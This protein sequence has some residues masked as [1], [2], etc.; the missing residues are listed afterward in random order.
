MDPIIVQYG[1]CSGSIIDD[2]VNDLELPSFHRLS[3]VSFDSQSEWLMGMGHERK[4]S[5][6]IC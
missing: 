4:M 2:L 1:L 6:S 5:Q 3:M